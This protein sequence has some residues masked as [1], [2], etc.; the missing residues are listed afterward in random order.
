MHGRLRC[1]CRVF[2]CV[3]G[4]GGCVVTRR[5]RLCGVW[6]ECWCVGGGSS[7]G[8]VSG[9][10]S[11]TSVGGVSGI[12]GVGGIGGVS[13]VSGVA[14]VAGVSGVVRVV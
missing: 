8:V 2:H 3:I 5:A 14:G 1:V 12:G 13:G 10:T 7:V 4:D 9:V 6:S 11:L